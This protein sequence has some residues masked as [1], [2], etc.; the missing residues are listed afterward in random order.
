ML[1]TAIKP[2]TAKIEQRRFPI[3]EFP[4]DEM[5][6]VALDLRLPEHPGGNSNTGD[7]TTNLAD[8]QLSQRHRTGFASWPCLHNFYFGIL[9]FTTP[10][11]KSSTLPH[12]RGWTSWPADR[13]NRCCPHPWCCAGESQ[14][15]KPNP[16]DSIVYVTPGNRESKRESIKLT[17]AACRPGRQRS[18]Q[19]MILG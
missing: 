1:I 14:I 17:P 18:V 2:A 13:L 10:H 19:V 15:G 5:H 12:F 9:A 16:L 8:K 4:F 11:Q 6:K 7:R 3:S